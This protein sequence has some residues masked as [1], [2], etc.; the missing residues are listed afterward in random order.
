MN[1]KR[2]AFTLLSIICFLTSCNKTLMEIT[3][4]NIT[5]DCGEQD[6]TFHSNVPFVDIYIF[7]YTDS[8]NEGN[9]SCQETARDYTDGHLTICGEWYKVEGQ[10]YSDENKE[11]KVHLAKNVGGPRKLSFNVLN[12]DTSQIV[13][14]IQSGAE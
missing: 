3:P 6:L 9:P 10:R 2:I 11:I 4:N 1:M 5:V 14:I 12:P 8:D 13:T 7:I